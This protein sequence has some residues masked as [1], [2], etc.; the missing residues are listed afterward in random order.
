MAILYP[1]RLNGFRFFVNPTKM[2]VQ[3]RSQISEAR[4]MAG[5]V[6]QVWPN[7]PDEITFEGIAFGVRAIT[8]LREMAKSIQKSPEEKEVEF[9]YKFSTYKGYVREL[10]VEAD[11]DNPR[12]YKYTFSFVSKTPF[13]LDS[14]PIGNLTGLKAEFDFNTAQL[15]GASTELSS[16]PSDLVNNAA[17]VFGQISGKTG[18]AT[19][20]LGIFIGRPRP[21]KI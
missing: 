4:T 14:M 13:A 17:A 7:L 2:G 8:E 16:I 10:K 21:F 15:R 20:G 18:S 5:T 1:I 19:Q 11:A 3:K 9:I 12:V 6:F